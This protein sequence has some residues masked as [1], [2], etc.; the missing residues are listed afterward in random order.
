[1]GRRTSL[2]DVE[3]RKIL[4]L[5][6]LGTP[7]LSHPVNYHF[8]TLFSLFKYMHGKVKGKAVPVIGREDPQGCERLRLP[9]FLDSR[10]IDGGE[11]VSLTR[12]PTFTPRKIPG[13]HFF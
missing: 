5:P 10:F 13:T 1:M 9:H 2:D 11:V 12:R 6:G 3:G 7:I 8:P 4:T